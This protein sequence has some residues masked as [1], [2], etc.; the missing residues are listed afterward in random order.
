MKRAVYP[1]TF[2][3]P[4]KGHVDIAYRA[5]NIFDELIIA[6]GENKSK[7][8]LFNLEER[9]DLWKNIINSNK[10][11]VMGFEGLIVDFMKKT[12]CTSIIRGLRAISDFEY[13]LQMASTNKKLYSDIDTIFFT[14]KEEQLFVSSTVVKEIVQFGGD[15]SDK[16][17]EYIEKA[18]ITK[19]K[20]KNNN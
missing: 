10:I 4:T 18:L 6:V 16:V 7:K 5:L 13:E 2:D 19:Y 15:V 11:T 14:A 3:P 17:H 9:I 20:L 12:E 1:G 8:C